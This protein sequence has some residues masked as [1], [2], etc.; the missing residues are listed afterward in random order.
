MLLLLKVNG[1]HDIGSHI[2]YHI[3]RQVVNHASVNKHHAVDSHRLEGSRYRHASAHSLGQSAAAQHH[4][5]VRFQVESDTTERYWQLV[6]I[7]RVVRPHHILK[8]IKHASC[9]EEVNPVLV[10]EER[11]ELL[12]REAH[13]IESAHDRADAR[14]SDIVDRHAHLLDDLQHAHLSSALGTSAAENESHLR[15]VLALGLVC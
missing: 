6:E 5:L 1:N 9:G 8:Q 2:P 11:V 14:A 15:A 7:Y 10:A 4:L 12:H 3:H 13:R